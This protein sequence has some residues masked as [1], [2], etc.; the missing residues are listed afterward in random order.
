MSKAA[1]WA[2]GARA[3][4]RGWGR[5]VGMMEAGGGWDAENGQCAGRW[6]E[7]L[8]GPRQ[9]LAPPRHRVGPTAWDFTTRGPRRWRRR[10]GPAGAFPGG[11]GALPVL[12]TEGGLPPPSCLGSDTKTGVFSCGATSLDLLCTLR[13][14]RE[15]SSPVRLARKIAPLPLSPHPPLTRRGRSYTSLYRVFPKPELRAGC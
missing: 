14:R 4:L 8:L 15:A 12:G 10:A 3:A 6:G 11:R 13:A 9:G 7:E 2:H 5:G 1:G